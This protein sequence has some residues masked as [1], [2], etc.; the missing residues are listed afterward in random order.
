MI[1]LIA[2]NIRNGHDVRFTF[3]GKLSDP[4]AYGSERIR[5]KTSA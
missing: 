3:I 5:L 2:E 4:D 1:H